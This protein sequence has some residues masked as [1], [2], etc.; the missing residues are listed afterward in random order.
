M[1]PVPLQAA[2]R[3]LAQAIEAPTASKAKAAITI[4]FFMF[5]LSVV[6]RPGA[7]TR[8]P[9]Y[10]AIPPPPPPSDNPPQKTPPRPLSSPRPQGISFRRCGIL[11]R[12]PFSVL[13]PVRLGL[14]PR[15]PHWGRGRPAR[16][17]DI[18]GIPGFRFPPPSLR[19]LLSLWSLPS[20]SPCLGGISVLQ[21]GP[22][23]APN[24]GHFLRT[25]RAPR[26]PSPYSGAS[27]SRRTVSKSSRNRPPT[28]RRIWY[29]LSA[30]IP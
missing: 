25:F 1:K 24:S 19:S 18:P 30:E 11:P 16:V 17:S 27:I 8:R 13:F 22:R 14:R 9:L 6:S 2:H 12:P 28:R 29:K 4:F 20:P 15:P 10:T 5:I 26:P 23:A 7:A 3:T 21:G